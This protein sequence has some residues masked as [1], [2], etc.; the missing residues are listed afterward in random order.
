LGADAE[1]PM[2]IARRIVAAAGGVI[3]SE[4]GGLLVVRYAW[5][6]AVPQFSSTT[7]DQVYTDQQHRFSAE[8]QFATVKTVNKL[9][10]MDVVPAGK[11]DSV[12]FE[13]S[14][15]D[16]IRGTLKVYPSPWRTTVTIEHTSKPEV[17]ATL[18]GIETEDLTETVEVI[19]G[20]GSVSHPI[21]Q[22]VTLE[23]LYENL[24]GVAFD[25]DARQFTTT[26]AT[27]KYSLLNI[28]YRTRYIAFDAVGFS[29]GTVQYLVEETADG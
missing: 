29:G 21:Y 16:P 4:P 5:P 7:P 1:V 9:R 18:R 28:T 14:E 26:H 13:A 12:E 6:V 22:V 25:V 10:L 2:D 8:E 11:G 15:L 24:T 27:K 20:A 23:W 19:E 3:E 17:S